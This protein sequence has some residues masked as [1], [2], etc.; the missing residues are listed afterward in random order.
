MENLSFAKENM[1]E[2]WYIFSITGDIE[3]AR[4]LMDS[5][6]EYDLLLSNELESEI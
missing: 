1:L 4:M 6:R 2:W 5:I 3:D